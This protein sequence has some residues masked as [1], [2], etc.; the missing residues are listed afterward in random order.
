MII[1]NYNK[2][3]FTLFELL[4]VIAII[5]IISIVAAPNFNKAFV[6]ANDGTAEQMVINLVSSTKSMAIAGRINEATI[7]FKSD[8]TIKIG[9][10]LYKLPPNFGFD[11]SSDK[12]FTFG[13]NGDV[14]PANESIT[15]K[16]NGYSKA[17]KIK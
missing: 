6:E 4:L 10:K 9:D 14:N 5:A 1:K 3:A 16:R 8:G 13:L 7:I 2:K 17:V 11:I 12:S 15:I